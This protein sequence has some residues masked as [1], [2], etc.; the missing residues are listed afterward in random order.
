MY[1]PIQHNHYNQLFLIY[2]LLKIHLLKVLELAITFPISHTS[3][4]FIFYYFKIK[5]LRKY[6]FLSCFILKSSLGVLETIPNNYEKS[7]YN[8]VI[9]SC[10]CSSC[11]N[12]IPNS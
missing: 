12:K 11:T 6:N 3:P 10:S 7:H 4:S 2:I 8:A 9:S 1:S 5:Q